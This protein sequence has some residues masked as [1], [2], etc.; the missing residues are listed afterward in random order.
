[1]HTLVTTKLLY[2]QSQLRFDDK[3]QEAELHWLS[4]TSRSQDLTI[5]ISWY[6]LRHL[7]RAMCASYKGTGLLKLWIHGS[8]LFKYHTQQT[9]AKVLSFMNRQRINLTAQ[10]G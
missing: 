5:F 10:R 2:L 9:S 7:T 1:M 8:R 4:K 6:D 3:K